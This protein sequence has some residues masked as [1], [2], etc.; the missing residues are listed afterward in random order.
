M[1]AVKG[2]EAKAGMASVE[3]EGPALRFAYLLALG[4]A[5]KADVTADVSGHC[6]LVTPTDAEGDEREEGTDCLVDPA[7]PV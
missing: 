1:A 5:S 7:M 6:C 2:D 3:V 4:K